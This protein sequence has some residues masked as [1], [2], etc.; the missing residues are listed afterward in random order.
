MSLDG[1]QYGH[2]RA[3][4]ES[5]LALPDAVAWCWAEGGVWRQAVEPLVE[6]HVR[7]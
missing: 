6:T 3:A 5:L 1:L 2:L 4:E 7:L